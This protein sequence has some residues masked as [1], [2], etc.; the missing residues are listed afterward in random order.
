MPIQLTTPL[1]TGALD[2]ADYTHA[3][4][5]SFKI[6]IAQAQIE[7]EVH[8][9]TVAQAVFTSGKMLYGVTLKKFVITGEDYAALLAEVTSGTGVLIY[10]E[11]SNA[12]YQWLLDESHYVGTI[13]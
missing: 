7:L 5:V 2:A 9:G 4:I 1:D 10:D 6:D 8:H 12:L 13:V 11:I 3:K